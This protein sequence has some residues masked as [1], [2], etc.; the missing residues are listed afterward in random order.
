V[1]GVAYL[2]CAGTALVCSLL[3]LRTYW[4]RRTRLLL[5]CGF[6]FLALT[7]EN[8]ALFVDLIIF[9]GIDLS[10]LHLSAALVGVILLLYGLIWESSTK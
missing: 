9:P 5:W 6:F 2:V 10:A 4:R 3:L 8:A 7:L 1:E